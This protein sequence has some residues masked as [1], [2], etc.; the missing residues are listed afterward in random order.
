MRAQN[1]KIP[2]RVSSCARNASTRFQPPPFI[3]RPDQRFRPSFGFCLC[4][5]SLHHILTIGIRQEHSEERRAVS[6]EPPVSCRRKRASTSARLWTPAFARV[7]G[8][9]GPSASLRPVPLPASRERIGAAPG[10][11][12]T[13]YSAR[14]RAFAG[15]SAP[16]RLRSGRPKGS[17][18]IS[19]MSPFSVFTPSL[20]DSVAVPKKWM[21]TSPG[22][23]KRAYLK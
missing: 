7:T 17:D 23:R 11:G 18:S 22:R 1:K 6:R 20:N 21:W 14:T 16:S 10:I 13:P 3:R 8:R 4:R 9:G 19:N 5:P 12:R 2:T 15:R